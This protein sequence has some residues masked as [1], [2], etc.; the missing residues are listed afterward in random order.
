[1]LEPY[2]EP[3]QKLTYQTKSAV[4][5]YLGAFDALGNFS[6]HSIQIWGKVFPTVEH[7]FQWKKFE[8]NNSE[9]AEKILK[10]K[11]AWLARKLGREGAKMRN[12]WRDIRISIMTD[13]IRAKFSQHEDAKQVLLSTNNKKIIENSPIDNYWGIGSTGK[14]ENQMGKILAKVRNGLK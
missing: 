13:I 14:G 2:P 9:W 3:G 8:S 12:D 5:F 10:A 11:S 4:Y 7:A 1:M 6:A